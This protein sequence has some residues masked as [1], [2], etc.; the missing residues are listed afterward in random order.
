MSQKENRTT[1]IKTEDEDSGDGK[2]TDLKVTEIELQYPETQNPVLQDVSLNIPSGEISTL[3][4]PN[5]SG[6][7]TLLKGIARQLKPNHGAVYVNGKTAAEYSTKEFARKVGFLSQENISPGSITV[8]ELVYHGRY[9]HRGIFESMKEDDKE[10]VDEALKLAG[11]THLKDRKLNS[12]SGGQKQLVWIAMVLAQRTDVILLDEPTT[13]LDLN[14]QLKVME[15]IETLK[16]RNITVVVV[17]HDI[18]QAA[19]HCDHVFALKDGEIVTE[20]GPENVVEKA[21]VEEVFEVQ[22]TVKQ[23]EWGPRVIPEEPI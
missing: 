6:K 17:L 12:L 19:K 8:E 5:G 23:S 20:G 2:E 22:V 14:H 10:A 15:I 7:S 16:E 9:P 18:N 3:V 21:L 1:E 11:V 13:Y 4:G